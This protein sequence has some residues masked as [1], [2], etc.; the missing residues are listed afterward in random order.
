MKRLLKRIGVI[1]GVLT[2]VIL[3]A[4]I[5]VYTVSNGR[6]N[7]THTIAVNPLTIPTDAEAIALGE[8]IARSRGCT[9]C[10]GEDFSGGILLDDPVV[11]TVYAANLTPGQGGIGGAYS[12]DD[13]LRALRH[14]VGPGGKA[15][16]IMPA[17]E[18]YYFSDEDTAALI[19]YL[20]TLPPVDNE[21]SENR[22]GPLARVLF[23]AGELPL[24]P[25]ELIAHNGP[26]P[27]PAAVGVTAE[28]GEYL[29][30]TCAG[31]HGNDFAGGPVPGAPPNIV[32]ANLTPGGN[33]QHWSEFDFTTLLRTG[34][35]PDGR[36]V[37]RE[38]MPV[39]SL[40]NLTD[41]EISALWLFLRSL[42]A[43]EQ[44]Q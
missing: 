41:D 21:N 44:G 37:D 5:G 28:Y 4:V 31:C 19:A 11:G 3:V 38:W 26:R 10:H 40:Q 16:W 12:G 34:I 30:V 25:A 17:H 13:Y 7:Q 36:Q 23:L 20:K 15:L 1:L 32:A 29:S 18:Y 33:L 42:P 35:T 27:T 24:L 9:D 22:A 43:V 6:I 8:H 14:G 2:A 39:N